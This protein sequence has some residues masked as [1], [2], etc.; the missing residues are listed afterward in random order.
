MPARGN[1]YFRAFVR[2]RLVVARDG[3][4]FVHVSVGTIDMPNYAVTQS[5]S[6]GIIFFF[7]EIVMSLVQKLAGIMQASDPRIVRVHGRAICEVLSVIEC[8]ALDF[9]DGFV[10]FSYGGAL[11]SMQRAPIRALQV[12]SRIAQVGKGVQIGRMLAL[13]SGVL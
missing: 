3:N 8:G 13:R 11:F 5:T 6:L 9:V 1:F 10:D 7:L 2:R 4:R 12:C